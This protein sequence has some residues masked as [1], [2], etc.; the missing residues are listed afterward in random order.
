MAAARG[1]PASPSP[2][3]GESAYDHTRLKSDDFSLQRAAGR[4]HPALLICTFTAATESDS[5]SSVETMLA[6]ALQRNMSFTE[7]RKRQHTP[8]TANRYTQNLLIMRT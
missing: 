3:P 7:D 6:S 1:E 5:G 8:G 4:S 2:R